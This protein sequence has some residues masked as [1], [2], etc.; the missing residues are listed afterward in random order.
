MGARSG[1][2]SAESH[3]GRTGAAEAEARAPVLAA[4]AAEACSGSSNRCRV[5]G[6]CKRGRTSA[7]LVSAQKLIATHPKGEQPKAN[8]SPARPCQARE[9][10]KRT[11]YTTHHH[12]HVAEPVWVKVDHRLRLGHVHRLAAV[13]R[14]HEPRIA[15]APAVN[16]RGG[17]RRRSLSRARV[18]WGPGSARVCSLSITAVL[19]GDLASEKRS[20]ARKDALITISA[21]G[22]RLQPALHADDSLQQRH[23]AADVA[24]GG[25][26]ADVNAHDVGAIHLLRRRRAPAACWQP[27]GLTAGQR[28]GI[29]LRSS[30]R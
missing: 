25:V 28:E 22:S 21:A 8:Q 20:P 27:V 30:Q 23:E 7:R 5:V 19:E 18:D 24:A 4:E 15:R 2:L 9:R 1:G 10:M 16:R 12:T 6:A 26:S 14:D 17:A 11:A 29:D 3:A 13:H